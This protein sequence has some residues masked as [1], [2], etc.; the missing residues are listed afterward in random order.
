MVWQ[1]LVHPDADVELNKIP[2]RERTAVATAL[3]KLRAIGP[4]LGHPHTSDIKTAQRLREL[5]PRQG[6]SPWRVFY[7][8]IGP[9]LV[10]GAIGPEADTDPKGFA[11]AVRSA[12]QRLDDVE[13]DT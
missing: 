8:Q 6:R 9:A 4:A 11:R 7:R 3:D 13:A 12:E 2:A 10:V 1:V 5:R